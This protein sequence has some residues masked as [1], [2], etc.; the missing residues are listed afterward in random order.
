[1]II[2]RRSQQRGLQH[3]RRL[4][5]AGFAVAMTACAQTASSPP[6]AQ[7][8]RAQASNAQPPAADSA[9]VRFEEGLQLPES[10]LHD[11]ERD[12]YLIS[13]INDAPL[14]KDNNGF[15]SRMAPD[16]RIVALKWI[17][18]GRNGVTLHAPKGMAIARGT[19]Y[20]ADIDEVRLFDA[21]TGAPK[22]SIAIPGA[23]FL[24]DVHADA[25]GVVYVSD[26][27]LSAG[28]DGFEP[29][30]SDAVHVIDAEGRVR[31]LAR[32]PKFG[33]PNGLLADGQRVWV[34]NFGSP[35]LVPLSADGRR[36]E[37]IRLP[38]GQLDGIVQVDG[39]LIVSSWHGA[40]LYRGRPGGRFGAIVT[41]LKSPGDIGYDAKRRRVIVPLVFENKVLVFA[42]P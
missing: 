34:A 5:A 25:S 41:G 40:A 23:T 2:T 1:M 8:S 20:V 16:G 18:G 15:I 33:L 22:R 36:G 6:S 7:A 29:N 21:A 14:G 4:L 17:E 28:K 32:D 11:V 38:Q 26:S 19:L 9:I 10:A 37:A 12:L 24:N 31:A 30:G 42:I 13:N 35:E 39:D 27:G 3:A